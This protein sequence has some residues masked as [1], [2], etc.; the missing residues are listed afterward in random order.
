M[1]MLKFAVLTLCSSVMAMRPNDH[2][3]NLTVTKFCFELVEGTANGALANFQKPLA[4][5]GCPMKMG[6]FL[7]ESRSLLVGAVQFVLLWKKVASFSA[8][9]MTMP[10]AMRRQLWAA[11]QMLSI[12]F[13]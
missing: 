4:S 6:N 2:T 9:V 13:A 1:G 10:P 8:A 3:E 5:H 7:L 12:F 11:R